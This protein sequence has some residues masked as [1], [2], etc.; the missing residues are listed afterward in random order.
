MR[1]DLHTHTYR[2]GDSTTT[3]PE[4]LEGLAAG[5]IDLAAITDHL[6]IE[7][8]LELA[9]MLPGRIIVGQEF[10][11]REGELI[12]LFL[13]Q[14]IPPALT[15][16]EAATL[17]RAQGGLVYVPHP[18]DRARSSIGERD[19]DN[20][21]A[22]GAIDVIEVAN[23]KIAPSGWIPIALKVCARYGIAQGAGSDAHVESAIGSTWIECRDRNIACATDLLEALSEGKIH[24]R[25]LDP[26]RAWRAR[27]VPSN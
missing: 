19:L 6:S 3:I 8:A 12:G 18:G 20:L 4:Y 13:T 1:L 27:I 10:R 25:H 9:E 17:I 5:E 15:A 21:A 2:S 24:T 16:L 26:P 22:A 23:S 11:V 14:R 7:G